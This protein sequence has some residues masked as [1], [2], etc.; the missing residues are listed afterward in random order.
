M[1]KLQEK[2]DSLKLGLY[3]HVPFC[4]RSCDFCHFY[5]EPPKRADLEAYLEG[6]ELALERTELPRPLDTVFWGGGTPGL[7]AAVD[8]ERLGKAVLKANGGLVPAEWSVEMAPATVKADKLK[9]FKDL[10]VSR[11]SVGV[12]SFQGPLLE[13]LGRIHSLEQ[14]KRAVDLLHGSGMKNFNL[15]LIFAIPGQS[16]QM[17]EADLEQAIAA[18]P[19]HISTYCL[20]FEEDT[21]LWLRLQRGQVRKTSDD[22]EAAYFELAWEKLAKGGYAQYEVSNFARQ[23][24]AC[25]H[26]LNTWRM[27]E[28]LG[29]GPSASSQMDGR[30]WTEPHSLEEWL[31]GLKSGKPRYADETT[32][33]AEI[34]AQDLLIFGLRMNEGV[35]LEG[36]EKR[37]P[38][39][40]P[41][42]W[43]DFCHSLI[44]ENLACRKESVLLLTEKGR[45]LADRIAQEIL[46]LE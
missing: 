40:L 31:D 23:G 38:E 42:E 24:Q 29:I 30:R 37:F 28:W 6:M 17:W 39:A 26:N 11:V 35:D 36:L 5:Q 13:A 1:E 34:L 22:E 25:M 46:E 14:V 33:N 45:L 41:E 7:L 9:V 19:A 18:D 44:E 32:L 21:A 8:L 2:A 10:G 3:V 16:L 12:Q 15:D 4:A 43:P 27:Q 20:T